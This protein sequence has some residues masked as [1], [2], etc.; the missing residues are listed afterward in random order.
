MK[1][2]LDRRPPRRSDDR[3]EAILDA[4]L[5]WLQESSLDAINVAAISKQAGVTRSG[6]YFYF[7]NKGA[8]VAA[9][10]ERVIDE[11]FRVNDAFV[12]SSASPRRRVYTMLEDLFNVCERHRPLFK[13]MLDARGSSASVREIW[14]GARQ[15]FSETT[16]RMITRERLMGFAPEGHD[17]QVLAAVL[18]ECND[19]LLER[20]VAGG[21]LS[22]AQLIEGAAVIWL[23]SIYGI[24]DVIDRSQ[25]TG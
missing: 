2:H 15:S 16:A 14:D 7:E 10:M 6:F 20:L 21:D 3:R 24:N 4:L 25:E 5:A 18:I 19:R 22:R 13:A 11:T 17:A 8:A 9:L 12:S 1:N 23:S